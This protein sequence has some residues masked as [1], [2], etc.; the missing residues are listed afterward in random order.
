[1]KPGAK[2]FFA[3]V[4]WLV[5]VLTVLVALLFAVFLARL[6][7]PSLSASVYL[8]PLMMVASGLVSCVFVYRSQR[9]Q[10][11]QKVSETGKA[12]S[13]MARRVLFFLNLAL[14]FMIISVF[15]GFL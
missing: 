4:E 13:L 3:A 6:D 8:G 5:S 14:N 12:I 7:S 11:S 15:W 10:P 9:R 1:V 2:S